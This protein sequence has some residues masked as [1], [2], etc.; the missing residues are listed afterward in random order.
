[1]ATRIDLNADLGES[2]GAYSMGADAEVLAFVTSANVACGFHAGDPS[3]IDRTVADAVRA[4]VAVGAHPGHW[5]LRGFGR[6]VIAADPEEVVADIVYQV[7]A[8]AGFAASHGT[9]LTHVKPHGA[10]Y[11]QAV[12]DER[13]AAAVARGV[14]RAGREL[15]LVGL[16]TSSIMRRAAEA[17]GLRFAAEAFADRVYERDGTLRS[18]GLRGAVMTDPQT[19]AA[20]AVRIA[21]EGVVTAGDGSEVRLQADTLCLHGDTEN[22]VALAR[23]VRGALEAAGVAVRALDR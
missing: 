21:R 3:V 13:L 19:V 4:G 10:L 18:R 8:L 2:F 20:Q 23:A 7:G 14:A 16:A 5:D 15:I 9:R 11:N 1:M 17:E 22:A 12:G 6:R